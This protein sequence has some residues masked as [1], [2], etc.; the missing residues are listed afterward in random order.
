MRIRPDRKTAGIAVYG[1]FPPAEAMPSTLAEKGVLNPQAARKAVVHYR[2]RDFARFTAAGVTV[3]VL[4][5]HLSAV[6]CRPPYGPVREVVLRLIGG[7]PEVRAGGLRF[8]RTIHFPARS[9]DW[10]RTAEA[11][12]ADYGWFSRGGDRIGRMWLD[13]AKPAGGSVA[14]TAGPS[15]RLPDGGRTGIRIDVLDSYYGGDPEGSKERVLEILATEFADAV[16]YAD[17]I[18]DALMGLGASPGRRSRAA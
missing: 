6:S 18:V 2:S 8:E 13:R 1:R 5:G 3:E 12:V 11:L 14:V 15:K 9:S 4:P 16:S 10:P 17:R 7:L